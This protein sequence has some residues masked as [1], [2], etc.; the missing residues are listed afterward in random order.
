MATDAIRRLVSLLLSR[1]QRDADRRLRLARESLKHQSAFVR[2]VALESLTALRPPDLKHALLD[3]LSD[4]S[5]EVRV[6][7]LEGLESVLARTRRCPA[8]V[9]PL[10]RD[11]NRLV[12]TQT[13]ELLGAVG[14][15]EMLPG[16]IILLR[17]RFPL[18]RRYAAE[19]IGRVG[20]A[21]DRAVLEG[22]IKKERSTNARV[23][24]YHGLYLLGS[25]D[26]LP[27]LISM[28]TNKNYLIRSAVAAS[29]QDTSRYQ[30]DARLADRAIRDVLKREHTSARE[31][32]RGTLA[33]LKSSRG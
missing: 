25:R 32:M 8:Q 17:D 12:R 29:L 15:R 33:V 30:S 31:N 18:V 23:G 19:A 6:A 27:K 1:G 5:W 3:G 11:P 7:A 4:R 28:L 13:A 16:L 26:I 9:R 22:R 21:R 20:A 2:R 14:D 10:L 24:L